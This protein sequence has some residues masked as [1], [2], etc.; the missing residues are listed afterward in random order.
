VTTAQ[1]EKKGVDSSRNQKEPQQEAAEQQQQQEVKKNNSNNRGR[2]DRHSKI[3][4]C[5]FKFHIVLY[6]THPHQRFPN[7]VGGMTW[8]MKK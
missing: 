5:E 8:K 2:T 1:K 7:S 3:I 6:C 4:N